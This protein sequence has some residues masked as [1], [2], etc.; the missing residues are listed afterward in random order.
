MVG[1]MNKPVFGWDYICTSL[2]KSFPILTRQIKQTAV[3]RYLRSD[4]VGFKFGCVRVMRT[5][6]FQSECISWSGFTRN[7]D[8]EPNE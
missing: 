6:P 3:L 2:K 1:N 8:A 4:V 5:W 7:L